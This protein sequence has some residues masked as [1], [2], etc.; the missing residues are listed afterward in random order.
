V[1]RPALAAPLRAGTVLREALHTYRRNFARVAGTAVMVFTPLTL[2]AAALLAKASDLNDDHGTW[3]N[4][5]AILLVLGAVALPTIGDVTFTGFLEAAVEWERHGDREPELR[6]VVRELPWGPLILTDIIVTAV[7]IAGA[8][9]FVI[10]GL[11]LA[12]LLCLSGPL[13]TMSRGGPR[14]AMARSAR[15]VWPHFGTTF[16]LVTVPTF[17]ERQAT[18]TAIFVAWRRPPVAAITA[19]VVLAVAVSSVVAMLQVTLAEQLAP[20]SRTRRP[21][22]PAGA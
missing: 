7:T 12:T 2:L 14:A 5:A 17:I 22:E 11:V 10:P 8:I 21:S 3:G 1:D 6:R 15:L 4:G 13:V 19:S 18:R 16:L 20:V 9:A